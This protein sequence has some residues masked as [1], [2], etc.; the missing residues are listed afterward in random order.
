MPSTSSIPT[1]EPLR[2][3]LVG[4]SWFAV[5]CHVP[6][7]LAL[8]HAASLVAI[9]SRTRKSM[10][11]AEARVKALAPNHPELRRH[12]K[13]EGMFADPDVDAVLLV[14]PIPLMPKAIEA[15]LRAGK[16][17]LSEKPAASTVEAAT[18]LLRLLHTLPSP[19]PQ[20]LVLENWA[21]KPSIRWLRQRLDEHAIGRVLRANCTHHEPVPVPARQGQGQGQG[22]AQGQAQGQTQGQGHARGSSDVSESGSTDW[23]QQPSEGG[24]LLDYGL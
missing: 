14:L 12:S 2:V 18:A 5:R 6:N 17:V 22:Q 3:G 11:K 10:A 24:W 20:W 4:C 23:R 13:M 8:P 15:A 7:L 21:H 9:C 1:A 19:A 16:H